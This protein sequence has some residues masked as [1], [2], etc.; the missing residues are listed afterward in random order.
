MKKLEKY[1]VVK[2]ITIDDLKELVMQKVKQD[3]YEVIGGAFFTGIC[4]CQTLVKYSD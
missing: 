3:N 4:F 1:D 2:A